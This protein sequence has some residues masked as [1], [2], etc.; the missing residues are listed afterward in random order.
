VPSGIGYGIG[1]E[2]NRAPIRF[3]LSKTSIIIGVF[4]KQDGFPKHNDYAW[5]T[6]HGLLENC[7]G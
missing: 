2:K 4:A 1:A 7:H 6:K 5:V 3:W